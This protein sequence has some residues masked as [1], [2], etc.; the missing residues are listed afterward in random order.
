VL[1]RLRGA[2]VATVT[3]VLGLL[4]LG[5]PLAQAALVV[6]PATMAH[7]EPMYSLDHPNYGANPSTTPTSTFDTLNSEA[8]RVRD[9]VVRD[10]AA[11]QVEELKKLIRDC[12][13]QALANAAWDIWYVIAYGG[14]FDLE[15]VL[16]RTGESCL[17]LYAPGKLDGRGIGSTF[18]STI[19][20]AAVAVFGAAP[21]LVG[22]ADWL[23]VV[24]YYYIPA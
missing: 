15:E 24:D 14:T 9:Q 16:T 13:K 8:S 20:N 17:H 21:D 5:G 4:A 11:A 22:L 3:A 12:G 1:K 7:N 6:D 23:Q 10:S 19:T 2:A 18:A